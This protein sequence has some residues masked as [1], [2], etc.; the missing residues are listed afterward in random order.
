MSYTVWLGDRLIGETDLGDEQ[1][2]HRF[3]SGNFTPIPGT[4]ALLPTTDSSLHLRDPSGNLVPTDWVTV[5]DLDADPIDEE[6]F[7]FDE[8]F[9]EE[10]EAEIEHDAAL[11]REWIDTREAGRFDDSDEDDDQSSA[12]ELSRYQIHLR[13]AED[14]TIQ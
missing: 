3:R 14:A 13:L 8:S 7:T 1:I 4:E 12:Q 5:Y 11:F 9:D 2:A 6:D 10:L